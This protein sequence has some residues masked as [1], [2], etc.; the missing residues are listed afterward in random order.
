MG[1]VNLKRKILFTLLVVSLAI[2]AIGCAS[3]ALFDNENKVTIDGIDF[4][5]PDGYKEDT[6]YQTI[7][8]VKNK[9]GVQYT[10]NGK[11]FEKGSDI[12]SIL[13]SDY[14]EYKL[15]DDIVKSVGGDEK[16]IGDVNGYASE[17]D[18]YYLFTYIK[19]DKLVVFSVT[20]EDSIEGFLK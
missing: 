18:G 16:T 20:G 9:G 19:D 17:D 8:E 10:V 11:V 5:V 12:V 2:V 13:V 7:N 1:E 4:N 15:T 3:A 6:N 14:G